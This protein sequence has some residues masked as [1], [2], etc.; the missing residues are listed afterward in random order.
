MAATKTYSDAEIS[1]F[2][3]SWRDE[4]ELRE[5]DIY[6]KY[7]SAAT[8]GIV[9][10]VVT[11]GLAFDKIKQFDW[12]ER[13]LIGATLLFL[14]MAAGNILNCTTFATNARLGLAELERELIVKGGAALPA[15]GLEELGANLTKGLGERQRFFRY[16]YV[17]ILLAVFLGVVAFY[18]ILVKA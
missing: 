15:D 14:I 2:I 16:T 11:I 1:A 4:L 7:F 12:F 9:T 18:T 3:K 5:K 6:D 13:G 10:V 17:L 8:G